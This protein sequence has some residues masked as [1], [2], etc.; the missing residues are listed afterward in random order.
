M[1][2]THDKFKSFTPKTICDA[3]KSRGVGACCAE[4]V[5]D[6]GAMLWTPGNHLQ[7]AAD[8]GLYVRAWISGS[9][10]LGIDPYEHA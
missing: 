2:L 6:M 9:R 8:H 7:S 4:N 1:L 10:S 3:T 5:D